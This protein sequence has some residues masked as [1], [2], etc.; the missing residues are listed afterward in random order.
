MKTTATLHDGN[1]I[2][3]EVTGE[4]PVTLLLPINPV[5][6]EGEQADAMRQWGADPALG[7]HLIDGLGDLAR[8]VAF[9]YEAECLSRPKPST[10]TPAN[11]VAD[12]LAVA[13][14]TD[15]PRFAWYGYSWLGVAGLQLAV[16]TDRVTGLAIGGWPPIDAP[17]AEM[18]AVTRAGWELATGARTSQG[19]VEWAHAYLQ[20]DQ[21][22]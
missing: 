12:I 17:Y 16:G 19:E 15:T 14:A 20:P 11:L 8:V 7:R 9:D 18:L 3:V 1:T 13:D 10:L 22:R 2:D 4:G 6:I 21:Q 5:P